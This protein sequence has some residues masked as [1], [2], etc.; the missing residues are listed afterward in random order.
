MFDVARGLG[1]EPACGSD[2]YGLARAFWQQRTGRVC[3][4]S[5]ETY[6]AMLTDPEQRAHHLT[7]V[8]PPPCIDFSIAGGRRGTD[9]NT[10]QLF[11]DDAEGALETD[12]PIVVSEIVLD[13]LDGKLITFLRQKVERLRQRFVAC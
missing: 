3:F 12:A 2:N 4:S 10:G 7:R 11:L 13:I 8:L 1:G 9:G 6:R 5:F